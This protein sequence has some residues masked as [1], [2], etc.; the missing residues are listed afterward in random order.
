M[1][2]FSHTTGEEERKAEA[3]IPILIGVAAAT[4]AGLTIYNKSMKRKAEA[5]V[6]PDGTFID[7]DGNRIHY[8]DRGRKG[9]PA[10]LLIHGLGGQMRNFAEPLLEDLERDYRLVL[11]DRPGSG[12][13]KRANGASSSLWQQAAVMARFIEAL[14]LDRP[15]V[16]GH[17]LG[18]A[19]ALTLA[20][21][22]PHAVS[23]LLLLCPLTQDQDTPPVFKALEIRSALMRRIV[24]NT[25]A[26]PIGVARQEQVLGAIFAPEPVP[27]HFPVEGG[28]ALGARC[29]AFFETSSDLCALEFQLPL[30]AERYA[31]IRVPVRILCAQEDNLLPPNLHGIK[32]ATQLPD[33]RCDIVPGGHMLPFTQ[34]DVVARWMRR[35]AEDGPVITVTAREEL[36]AVAA[37]TATQAQTS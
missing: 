3:M 24:A 20:A 35:A 19:L 29:E 6:P 16:V 13:S 25:V 7:I 15:I 32:T 14:G 26:V 10:M 1:L 4:A 31:S 5:A 27:A 18:G 22:H 12:W 8:V 11:V 30:L 37:E 34:P 17:S 36:P 23:R 9:A 28:A 2:T 33:G 21:E